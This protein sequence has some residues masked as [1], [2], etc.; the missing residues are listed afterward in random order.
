MGKMETNATSIILM[1]LAEIYL[2]HAEALAMTGD[3]AG[4]LKYV[5]AVRLRAKLPSVSG[6][7]GGL[8]IDKILDERR[9]EL[10][11]EGFRFFDLVR[12]DKAIDVHNSVWK[13]D[14][15]YL[16]RDPLDQYSIFLPVPTTVLDTNPNIE[17]NPGY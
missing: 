15:Y 10:A 17:Q 9:L 16:T 6:L 1:R 14:S 4:A 3:S 5:N 8:L 13:D 7:A 11:F 2:L 12:H